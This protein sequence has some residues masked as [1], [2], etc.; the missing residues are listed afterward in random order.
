M[1]DHPRLLRQLLPQRPGQIHPASEPAARPEGDGAAR[2]GLPVLQAHA[3]Q[4]AARD[5]PDGDAAREEE[6]V[7]HRE[8][9]HERDRHAR[10]RALVQDAFSQ[11]H[12]GLRER[13]PPPFLLS[14]PPPPPPPPSST[15]TR[16]T[17]TR[18]TNT[19]RDGTTKRK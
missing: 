17:T 7:E 5:A 12:L 18:T 11:L 16:G 10:I 8:P 1:G 4:R 6:A 19:R 14:P 9:E 2:R 13:Q 15:P 3:G